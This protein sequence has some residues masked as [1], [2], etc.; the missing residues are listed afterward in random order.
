MG[1]PVVH[2]EIIGAMGQARRHVT[3]YVEVADVNASLALIE[4]KGG[5]KRLGR[6]RCRPER[7]SPTSP[8]PKGTW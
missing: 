7:T 1:N 4:S 8:P 5:K 6:I 2:F 3:F